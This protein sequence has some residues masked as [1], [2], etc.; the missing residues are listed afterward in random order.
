MTTVAT[1]I[2]LALKDIGIVG[3]GQTA[4]AEDANDALTTL[5]QMLAQWQVDG[6]AVYTLKDISFTATGATSYTIGTGGT[7]DRARVDDVR[8][9]FYRLNNSDYPLTVIDSFLDYELIISKSQISPPYALHYQPTYP[10]G[11]LYLYPSP[12]SGEIHLTIYEEFTEYAATSDD[13][14]LPK[15]YELAVRYSLA[16]ILKISYPG[17][18]PRQDISIAAAKARRV[19]KRSNVRLSPLGLPATVLRAKRSHILTDT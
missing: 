18:D 8:A 15:K 16:E 1:V 6:L 14:A 13:L 19:L 7:I 12:S 4:S 10:L 17:A 11:T 2:N 9:G 5:N 3:V